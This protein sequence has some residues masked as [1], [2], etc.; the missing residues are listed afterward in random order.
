MPTT[1]TTKEDKR[2]MVASSVAASAMRKRN[3][4]FIHGKLVVLWTVIGARGG[5]GP[6]ASSID[7]CGSVFIQGPFCGPLLYSNPRGEGAVEPAYPTTHRRMQPLLHSTR[8]HARAAA[9]CYQP[10]YD[11]L[12]LVFSSVLPLQ[13]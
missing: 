6:H 9:P 3:D 5:V 10:R 11:L 7:V 13:S 4:G 8:A 2:S 12:F 1:S